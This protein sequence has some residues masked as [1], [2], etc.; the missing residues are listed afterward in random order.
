[1]LIQEI[2]LIQ[3]KESLTLGPYDRQGTNRQIFFRSESHPEFSELS[4]KM[5][6][7]LWDTP[8]L[9][10]ICLEFISAENIYLKK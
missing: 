3:K 8:D 4:T 2:Q 5:T 10:Y 6:T 7:A 9:K 1:M